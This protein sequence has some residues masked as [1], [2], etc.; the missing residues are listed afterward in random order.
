[1]RR[2]GR[3]RFNPMMVFLRAAER[4][5]VGIYEVRGHGAQPDQEARRVLDAK[6]TTA[7]QAL[8]LSAAGDRTEEWGGLVLI[9]RYEGRV[10]E[11][12]TA[13]SAIRFMCQESDQIMDTAAE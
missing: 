13:A 6:V 5:V 8:G 3:A 11:P 10:D 1:M 7:L 4:L 9:R 12:A 2:T